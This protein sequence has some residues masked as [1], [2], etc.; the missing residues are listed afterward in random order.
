MSEIS[1]SAVNLGNLRKSQAQGLNFLIQISG[2]MFLALC[3]HDIE[4]LVSQG[5]GMNSYMSA[6]SSALAHTDD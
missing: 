4:L 5:R 6:H 2:L 3:P 1:S